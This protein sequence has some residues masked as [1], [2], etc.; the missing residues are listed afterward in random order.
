[1]TKLLKN[2]NRFK[3]CLK[4][5]VVHLET[6]HLPEITQSQNFRGWKGPLEIIKFNPTAKACSLQ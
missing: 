2:R 6:N 3:Y 1:M 5:T 4:N